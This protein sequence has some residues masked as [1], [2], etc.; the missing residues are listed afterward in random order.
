[1]KNEKK[2]KKLQVPPIPTKVLTTLA[3]LTALNAVLN[4]GFAIRLELMKFNFGFVT[5]I[6]A[7]IL[8]G[9]WAS[10]AVGALGDILGLLLFPVVGA[11]NPIF[12]IIAGVNGLIYGLC[13]Y[14][15]KDISDKALMIRSGIAAFLVTQIMYTVV[16]SLV[17]SYLYGSVYIVP[18]D[19]GVTFTLV[20][21]IRILKNIFLFFVNMMIIPVVFECKQRLLKTG[22]LVRPLGKSGSTI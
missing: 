22:L 20:M 4:D 13:L 9:P 18:T 3:L 14:S 7:A 1:M 19:T 15:K 10:V 17:L 11:P 5:V 12:T 8:Y 21:W 2:I 6:M 16:N